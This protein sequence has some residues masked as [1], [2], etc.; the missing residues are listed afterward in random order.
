MS[1]TALAIAARHHGVVTS[2]QLTAAGLSKNAIRHLVRSGEWE[3]VARGVLAR[4]GVP[5]TPERELVIA[6]RSVGGDAVVSHHSAAWLWGSPSCEPLPPAIVTTKRTASGYPASTELHSVR[7]LPRTWVTE[8]GGIP[9]ARPELVALHTF[10]ANDP[11]RAAKIVD[12]FW[13]DRLLSGRSIAALLSQIGERGRN[14]TAGL[15]DYLDERGYDFVPP[16]SGIE[17]RFDWLLRRELLEARRQVDLGD[18]QW[19]ARVD[20]LIADTNVIVEVQSGRFHTALTD[21]AADARRQARVE[22]AGFRVVEVTDDELWHRPDG[23]MRR[24]RDA[25]GECRARIAR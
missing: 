13:A 6:V 1:A 10:A 15:R 14:G 25:V 2:S 11:Q 22:G 4:R 19:C 7:Q 17:S 3:R 12:R 18:E 9:I 21:V 5:S 8:L 16:A 20:F 24:I 23:A